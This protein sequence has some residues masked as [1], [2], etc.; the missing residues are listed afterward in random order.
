M[1]R[2]T[3]CCHRLKIAG[4]GA[5]ASCFLLS[6]SVPSLADAPVTVMVE[7]RASSVGSVRPETP[8]AAE[9]W[10][11]WARM[12]E[13]AT[14][15]SP[16]ITPPDTAAAQAVCSSHEASVLIAAP[17]DGQA[18]QAKAAA[19]LEAGLYRVAAVIIE[20]SNGSDTAPASHA[21]RMESVLLARGGVSAKTVHLRPG[22][23]LIVRWTE[24][25]SEARTVLQAARRTESAKGGPTTY[26]GVTISKALNQA[27]VL[28]GEIQTLTARGNRP[29]AVRRT[30]RALL[31]IAQAQA[32]ARNR[33]GAVSGDED[34]NTFAQVTMAFSEISAAMGNLIPSESV[35]P[36]KEGG[37]SELKGRPVRVP[38]QCGQY[39]DL[40]R[41]PGFARVGGCRS[42]SGRKS[43][44]RFSECRLGSDSY[45]SFPNPA[46][47]AGS[48]GDRPVHSGCRRGTCH[49]RPSSLIIECLI[50]PRMNSAFAIFPIFG[51]LLLGA[52]FACAADQTGKPMTSQLTY[53]TARTVDQIDDYHGVK[54]P[55]PYRW[56]E[57][58]DSEETK[59]WVEAENKVTSSYLSDIPARG[60]IQKRLTSLWNYE[61]F[62]IPSKKGTRYF[63]T[64]NSGL[65]NQAVLYVSDSLQA[66]PH[67]LLDPNTL[68]KD[69]TV[70][71]SGTYVSED[72]KN[73]AY[74]I[75]NA[76]SDWVE[77]RVRDIATGKDLPDLIQ[78]VKFS[79]A[80]WT[81]DGKGFFYSRYDA[82]KEGAALQ[83]ANYNQKLFYHALGEEQ[84]KD[85][86]VYER[87]D[88][89]DWGFYGGVSDD[90]HYLVIT[91]TQG[92]ERKNR[93]FYKDLSDPDSKI[94]GLLTDA[95]ASYGF[96]GN[97]GSV[98]YF[99]T[100]NKATNSRI[101]AIDTAKPQLENWREVIKETSE[102][103]DSVSLFG[104][105]FITEYLKDAHSVV[106]IF[107]SGTGALVR[108][109][110][111]PGLGTVSG[112]GGDQS[113]TETFYAFT[114]YTVPTTIYHYDIG[115]GQSTIFKK[116]EVAF[117]R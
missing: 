44:E 56:L 105:E 114:S 43:A 89:P 91:S 57:D 37:L 60:A 67:V 47:V 63:Y 18:L 14:I 9:S 39:T 111:L 77:F 70:A 76:G 104:K 90:G 101:I 35:I 61:R 102:T 27:S 108:E 80:S 21:W 79:G 110:A 84:S 97:D 16:K 99:V 58:A 55:D 64:R 62:G 34:D 113:D 30:H 15:V 1:L 4:I 83:Q 86:L 42:G 7:S 46:I 5:T 17:S 19:A 10:L 98:F 49:R 2:L 13:G 72:G 109:M 12:G 71:L 59:A 24:T 53:P 73:L 40:I 38:D 88:H 116:P 65:Q 50:M 3:R 85:Q 25:I 51:L 41:H 28:L 20:P 32:M 115:S 106:K 103:M 52:P 87:P 26:T 95:D 75:A 68:S 81:K 93:V 8:S 92:T 96:V 36:S 107:S 45:C 22:Q 33:P 69:G 54:V 48:G 66:E 100:N 112:F 29:E 94:V 23:I 78:W 31:Y 82:P 74:G 117:A 11:K 6:F